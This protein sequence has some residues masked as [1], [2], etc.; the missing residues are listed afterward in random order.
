MRT[1]ARL[2]TR[3]VRSTAVVAT[4]RNGRVGEVDGLPVHVLVVHAVVVLVPLTSL[5]L[6]LAA[7]WPAAR[8]RLGLGLPLAA[9]VCLLL[10]PVTAASGQWLADRTPADPLLG[11]HVQLGPTLLPWVVGLV[12]AALAVFVAERRALPR[13]AQLALVVAALVVA[14]GAT[15]TT[16]RIGESGARSVWQDRVQAQPPERSSPLV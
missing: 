4:G 3:P 8:R 2:P 5:A 1:S 11:A 10:V 15:A 6:V 13:P 12:L 14:V 7:V 9:A 16:Y